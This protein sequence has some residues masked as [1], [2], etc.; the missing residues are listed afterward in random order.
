MNRYILC[1]IFLTVLSKLGC[2][3][4]PSNPP[5]RPRNTPL[6]RKPHD[7]KWLFVFGMGRSGST[8]LKNMLNQ[9]PGI[10]IGGELEGFMESVI[11]SLRLFEKNRRSIENM[12]NP[13]GHYKKTPL[14]MHMALQNVFKTYLGDV[15]QNRYIGFKEVR[16]F[17]IDQFNKIFPGAK[18]I[19]N[20]RKNISKLIQ[21]Q[22]DAHFD[23]P[24][25]YNRAE[26]FKTKM[27][28]TSKTMNDTFGLPLEDFTV[29]NFNRLLTWLG[30]RGC[31]YTA[32]LHSNKN[33]YEQDSSRVL[34]GKCIFE[35]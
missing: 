14:K 30:I 2:L 20:W 22:I 21:S 24:I 8:T 29:E 11:E 34:E 28:N 6:L 33:G 32:V 35:E 23:Y 19:M 15:P 4:K 17:D 9:V 7:Q 5:L 13:N 12:A 18:I 16:Y 27:E 31:H 3:W 25:P 10:Y 1:I 26:L